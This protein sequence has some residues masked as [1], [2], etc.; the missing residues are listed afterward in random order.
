MP[1]TINGYG[2]GWL[3]DLPDYRDF[4]HDAQNVKPTLDKVGA[5]E[6]TAPSPPSSVDLRQWCSPIVDQK[7]LGSCTA[8]ACAGIVGYFE[9]KAFGTY[10]F[11]SMLFLY[12]ATRNL[13]HLTGDTG[14]NLRD[15]MKA[16]T[17]FGAPPEEYW[18]YTDKDPDFDAEPPAFCYAFGQDYKAIKYYRLDPP[19]TPK[20]VLLSR[21]KTNLAAQ[22]PAMFGFTVY[23]SIRRVAGDGKIPFPCGYENVL[24]G[25]AIVAVGYDDSIKIVNACNQTTTGALLIRNSWG[26]GW[27]MQGYGWLPYDYVLKG[28]AVDWWSLIQQDWIDLGGFGGG[29]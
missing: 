1:T 11:A 10:I 26:T 25:H 13:L 29:E 15:V 14:A 20:D 24:G 12:K 27:G 28:L 5:Y 2:T 7:Q 3:R 4:T 22:L 6:P 23:E 16:L 17:L 18:P 19:A 9:N 8:N 21:I